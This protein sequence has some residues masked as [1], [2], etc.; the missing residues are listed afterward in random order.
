[1]YMKKFLTTEKLIIDAISQKS[2]GT[3]N[4]CKGLSIGKIIKMLRSQ[5]GMPQ[6]ILAKKASVRQ[7]TISQIEQDKIFPTLNTLKKI[8]E[9]LGCD[10]VI[11]FVLRESIENQRLKQA[12]KQAKK[13]FEYLKGTMSLEKQ[14]IDSLMAEEIMKNE[15]NELL[16]GSNSKLWKE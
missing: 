5:L 13:H 15:I 14:P 4:A 2:L 6:Q 11:S 12:Q 3:K 8:F 7:A 10:L 1:M 9:V 16:F